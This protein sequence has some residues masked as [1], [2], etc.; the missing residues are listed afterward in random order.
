[1]ASAS[2]GSVPFSEQIGFFLRKLNVTTEAWTD[3]LEAEHDV[4]F[5]V[6]GANRDDMVADFREAVRRAIEDGATLAQFRRDFDAIVERYGWQYNG[7]RN[8]RS[9]V[10]YETNLRQSYNAGRWQQLQEIKAV[11]PYWRYRHSDAVEH[12]RPIHEG[13]DGLILHADDPWWHTHFPANGWG[14][15]CY[16]EGLSERDLVRLGKSGPDTAP[17]VV[18]EAVTIGARSPGGPRTIMTPE[19]IDPGFGYA[20]GRSVA[21]GQDFPT[22]GPDISELT[23]RVA[24]TAQLALEKTLRLPPALAAQSA[25]QVLGLARVPDALVEG[26]AEWLGD[27]AGDASAESGARY[28]VGAVQP[29]LLDRLASSGLGASAASIALQGLDARLLLAASRLG[30]Q[31]LAQV[32]RV[33]RTPVAVLLD[34]Q[35]DV[36]I[37][38]GRAGSILTSVQVR[39]PRLAAVGEGRAAEVIAADAADLDTLRMGV[40]TGR[41]QLIEGTLET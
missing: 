13:W 16:V 34:L 35:E 23:A 25:D 36:V 15:Q 8:W 6:A 2:Y 37:F 38:V 24:R 22:L 20:P 39:V 11:R 4:A 31:A 26:L 28:L 41:L 1:M 12:P 32:P 19:G 30:A 29:A 7:G 27:V 33:L 40:A 10:I 17:P 18:M 14:C 21:Q 5:M 9:R 3:V